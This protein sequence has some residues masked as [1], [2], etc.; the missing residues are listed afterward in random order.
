MTYET[1]YETPEVFRRLDGFPM[2]ADI[3]QIIDAGWRAGKSSADVAE[4]V[5]REFEAPTVR[6]SQG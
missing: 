5:L 6:P 1:P 3:A 2:L 4:E